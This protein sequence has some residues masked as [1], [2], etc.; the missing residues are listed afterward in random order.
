VPFLPVFIHDAIFFVPEINQ[1]VVVGQD[2]N[3]W[4]IST[5][6]TL[7][8]TQRGARATFQQRLRD[9]G[10]EVIELDFLTPDKVAQYCYRRGFLQVTR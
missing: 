4:D 7:V 10:V 3:L 5:A 9:R 1:I 8:I 2:A 6:P